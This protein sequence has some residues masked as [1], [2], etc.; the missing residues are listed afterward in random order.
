[1][2]SKKSKTKNLNII[3][4]SQGNLNIQ[5][6]LNYFPST[7]SKVNHFISLAGDLH[8]IDVGPLPLLCDAGDLLQAGCTPATRQQK[9]G[10]NFLKALLKRGD[11][12]LVPT[13]SLYTRYDEVIGGGSTAMLPGAE[14]VAIQDP[15]VCG[16]LALAEHFTMLVEPASFALAMTKI[17]PGAEF[18][19]SYC[20]NY[21][22]G[23]SK[24]GVP[25]FPPPFFLHTH[26]FILLS[27]CSP[28]STGSGYDK[29]TAS[30]LVATVKGVVLDLVS[31]VTSDFVS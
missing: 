21:I 19:K 6:A 25:C 10:S 15:D 18:S 4:H 8:G 30:K 2:L 26:S 9:V 1:M 12:A 5:F 31:F 3:G 27:S 24:T 14:N 29:K 11:R 16:P 20:N 28:F 17:V 7:R 13:L 23:K 22:F